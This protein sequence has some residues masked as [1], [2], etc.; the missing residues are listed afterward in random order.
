VSGSVGVEADALWHVAYTQPGLTDHRALSR[1]YQAQQHSH[2]GSFAGT[3][4]ADERNYLVGF[5]F[6]VYALQYRPPRETDADV[7]SGDQA[8]QAFW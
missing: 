7:C 2:Q 3:V 8:R 6:K 4:G 5:H 1:R